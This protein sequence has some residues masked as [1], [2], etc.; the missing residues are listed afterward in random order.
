MSSSSEGSRS[1]VCMRPDQGLPHP[2]V[3]EAVGRPGPLPGSAGFSKLIKGVRDPAMRLAGSSQPPVLLGASGSA[4]LDTVLSQVAGG[5]VVI[6]CNGVFGDRVVELTRS[7]S[8]GPIARVS[9]P[10][11]LP[12][13]PALWAKTIRRHPEV[14]VIALVHS[15]SSTGVRNP[16]RE[17]LA[18]A[19]LLAPNALTVV[20]AIGSFGAEEIEFDAWGIDAMVATLHKAVAGPSSLAM[21]F[22][23]PRT[24]ERL[25]PARLQS[26]DLRAHQE[27]QAEGRWLFAPPT[28]QL[29]GACE[30]L[31]IVLEIGQATFRNRLRATARAVR[32]TLEASGL[33]CVPN[34]HAATS[35]TVVR[36][37]KGLV[38][39]EVVRE[40]EEL[41]GVLA[42]VGRGS[43]AGSTVRFGHFGHQ[44]VDGAARAALALCDLARDAGCGRKSSS[45]DLE[46]TKI[47]GLQVGLV[48]MARVIPHEIYSYDHGSGLKESIRETGHLI[49]PIVV[50]PAAN[51]S[52]VVGDGTHRWQSAIDLDC[53][54]IAAQIVEADRLEIRTWAHAV[55]VDDDT[56]LLDE[57]RAQELEL[58]KMSPGEAEGA[59]QA[60]RIVAWLTLTDFDSCW[61]VLCCSRGLGETWRL[62]VETYGGHAPKRLVPAQFRSGG[63]F[64]PV[65]AFAASPEANMVVR[66]A[67]P[68]SQDLTGFAREPIPAGITRVVCTGGRLLGL[69]VPLDLLETGCPRSQRAG[70]LKRLGRDYAARHPG[71]V[72]VC[73]AGGKRRYQEDVVICDPTIEVRRGESHC[74]R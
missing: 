39:A 69:N 55:R 1:T 48:P 36:L 12:I 27:C 73:E 11:G 74:L 46:T 62:I 19:R 58:M 23:S 53:E 65:K 49:H 8:P 15:E 60:G 45:A 32:Q 50:Y 28:P 16:L 57:L 29:L 4:A 41:H 7:H 5:P 64:D 54:W 56:I 38:P 43:L 26:V 2:R 63:R 21:V 25:E 59:L 66:F 30:A 33:Q 40:L 42:G 6:G 72:F 22:L 3:Q 18:T 34:E 31:R 61:G 47:D 67:R 17:L 9:S 68:S 44:S 20:D 37:P 35:I 70:W 14:A 13:D 71:P 51:G 10:P 52:F 24:W